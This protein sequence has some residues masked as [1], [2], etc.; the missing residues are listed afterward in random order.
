MKTAEDYQ[1]GKVQYDEVEKLF[2][3]MKNLAEL[4]PSQ[5]EAVEKIVSSKDY[6]YEVRKLDYN[7]G[8]V[9]SYLD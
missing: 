3:D 8:D 2:L 7:N 6:G 5:S 9:G 1:L 4:T